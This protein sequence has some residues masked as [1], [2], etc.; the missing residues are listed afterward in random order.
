[1]LKKCISFQNI[2]LMI[3]ANVNFTFEIRKPQRLAIKISVSKPS[4]ITT[5]MICAEDLESPVRR[6]IDTVA[7]TNSIKQ[8]PV[9]LDLPIDEKIMLKFTGINN[10]PLFTIGQVQINIL[11]YPTILNIIEGAHAITT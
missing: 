1:M 11:G 7:G 5:I 8:I 9:N 2:V 3:L 10:L 6:M 4:T